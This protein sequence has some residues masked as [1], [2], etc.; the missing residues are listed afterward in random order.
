M[1]P[2]GVQTTA[3]ADAIT[4]FIR[5]ENTERDVGMTELNVIHLDNFKLEA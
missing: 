5:L 1:A 2:P 4:V 3:Q